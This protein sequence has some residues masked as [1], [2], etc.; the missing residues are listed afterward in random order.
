MEVFPKLSVRKLV[1]VKPGSVCAAVRSG[2]LIFGLVVSDWNASALNCWIRFSKGADEISTVSYI[3]DIPEFEQALVFDGARL[4]VSFEAGTMGSGSYTDR[5]S[6]GY[7]FLKNGKIAI[8]GLVNSEQAK[9]FYIKDGSHAGFDPKS[10]L[11][12]I[13]GD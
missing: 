13:M 6:A 1:E 7:A 5:K 11:L 12:Q 9:A 8:S 10:E 2:E 4:V 3:H